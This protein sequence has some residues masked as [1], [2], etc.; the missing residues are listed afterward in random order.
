M[1][2]GA[3]T[4]VRTIGRETQQFSTIGLYLGS[5]FKMKSCGPWMIFQHS[6]ILLTG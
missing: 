2:D 5:T 6:Y 1:N 4:R 3:L